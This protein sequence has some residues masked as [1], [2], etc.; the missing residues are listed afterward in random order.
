MSNSGLLL[1]WTYEEGLPLYKEE[2][3]E[4]FPLLAFGRSHRLQK[5][6][7][8]FASGNVMLKQ[9]S[10]HIRVNDSVNCIPLTWFQLYCQ[11]YLGDV[12]PSPTAPRWRDFKCIACSTLVTWFQVYFQLHLCDVVSSVFPTAHRWRDFKCIATC[13]LVTWFQ[14]YC[15]LHLDD[16][17][18]R[19]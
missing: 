2:E 19:V 12:I 8:L 4:Y 10:G 7:R 13:T 11:L 16:V 17:I 5:N 6:G 3:A 18:L 1:T 14:V 9:I 15:Q